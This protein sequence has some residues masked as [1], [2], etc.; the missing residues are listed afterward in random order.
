MVRV[1][2][3]L[4]LV[5]VCFGAW[6]CGEDSPSAPTETTPAVPTVSGLAIAGA[7]ALRTSSS[8]NY[9]TTAT[10]SNGTT[11]A[12]TPT[13][14]S[15]NTSVATINANGL[16][17]GT[18][19]GS[20]TVTATHQGQ[21]ASKTVAVV[22]NYGGSWR[23]TWV[24]RACDQS[25]LFREVAWCQGLGGAGATLPIQISVSQTGT[26]LSQ[27]SALVTID[28]GLAGTVQGTVTP[29]GRLNLA[30]SFNQVVDG[31]T[32]Q[33]DISAWDTNLV[34]AGQLTGRWV[35]NLT[36]VNVNGN[37]YHEGDLTMTQ[38]ATTVTAAPGA[39][40]HAVR[41]HELLRRIR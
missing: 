9:T 40:P 1:T 11:Q 33:F 31:V 22:N 23:G 19:H 24:V 39:S 38:T 25:G 8:S 13:W 32:F 36:A 4:A 10:L 26:G 7:D 30:G 2:V 12:V 14:T 20:T 18:V 5:M 27:I 29:D 21:T 37:A 41:W 17:N 6:A 34:S 28:A 35:L 3:G 15:S 16:L